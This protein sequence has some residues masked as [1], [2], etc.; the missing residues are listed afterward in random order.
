MTEL[1]LLVT[2]ITSLLT[3]VDTTVNKIKGEIDTRLVAELHEEMKRLQLLEV[4]S[5]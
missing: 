3:R 4:H 1:L 2:I 5:Q